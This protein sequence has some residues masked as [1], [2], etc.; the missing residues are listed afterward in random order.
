MVCCLVILLNGYVV[1]QQF[2]QMKSTTLSIVLLL[3]IGVA[4]NAQEL[5]VYTD[6]ASNVPARSLTAKV[7][8]KW[9]EGYHSKR[10]EWRFMPE[11]QVGLS[12]KWM[13]RANATFS[14]M[15]SSNVRWESI[16]LYTKYR[17]LSQD[18][19]HRH[20]RMAAFAEAAHSVNPVFYDELNLDG[21]QSGI[22]G[23]LIATQLINKLAVSVSG[24][25][26]Y[27]TSERP[28]YFADAFPYQALNYTASAGY[29][30][31][32]GKYTSYRQTNLNIYAELLGQKTLDKNRF[33]V[34]LAP[35]VQLIF[36]SNAK[37]NAGYRFQL[38]GNMHRMAKKQW[39]V[40]FE[41]VFLN[42]LGKKK[43]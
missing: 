30:L 39:L 34:D 22:R 2:F 20:F 4:G 8:G 13:L 23:G 28:K 7:S 12:K 31:F 43:K 27:V 6:P 37:L 29:L 21:D 24:S 3:A 38:N 11:V 1:V 16:R 36:N 18:D 9:L 17:F 10:T 26:L 42:A 5:Y 33:Y 40:S 25:Y 35:A 32:P 14:D 19:L 15:Y 41:Y